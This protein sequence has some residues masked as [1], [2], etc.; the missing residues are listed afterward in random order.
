M[1]DYD[2][3]EKVVFYG[4]FDREW[5]ENILECFKKM[6][7]KSFSDIKNSIFI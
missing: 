3:C 6:K 5:V 4:K 2:D 7:G 1:E